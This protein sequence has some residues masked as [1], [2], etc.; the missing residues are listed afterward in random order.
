MELID[1]VDNSLTDKNTCHSYLDTYNKLLTKKQYTAKNILEVGIFKGGSI[2]LWNEYFINA[3][4]YG[5]D[6]MDIKN[7]NDILKN[8]EKIIL[9][10]SINAYDNN[11]VKTHFIDKKITF[12]FMLDDGPHTLDS[13]VSFIRL[14]SPLMTDDGILAVEDIQSIEWIDTL[15]NAVPNHLKKIYQ[16]I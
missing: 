16:N 13:M 6:I 11:F 7:V 12:D 5:V 15:K 3:I 10:T 14:Y 4:I 2:K 9:Y 8:N 1:L